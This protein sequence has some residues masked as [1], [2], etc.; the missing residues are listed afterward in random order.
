MTN[1]EFTY[2]LGKSLIAPNVERQ[3]HTPNNGLQNDAI[4]KM[5]QVLGIVD[6]PEMPRDKNLIKTSQHVVAVLNV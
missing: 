6:L 2:Q 3:Y 4:R 1:Y 5:K